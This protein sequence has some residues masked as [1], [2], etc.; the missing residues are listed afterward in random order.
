M[1]TTQPTLALGTRVRFSHPTSN[2]GTV[3]FTARVV[4]QAG[5]GR[6][7]VEMPARVRR[8]PFPPLGGKR[9]GLYNVADLVVAK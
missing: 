6:V 9:Y 1:A 3:T 2:G 7:W 4:K 5:N 8:M